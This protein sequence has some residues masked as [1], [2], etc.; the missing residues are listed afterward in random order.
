[1]TALAV[2]VLATLGGVDALSLVSLQGFSFKAPVE[3]AK[4]APDENSLE[5]TAPDEVAKFAVSAYPTEKFM[6]PAGCIKK[7]LEAVGKEGFETMTL[8]TQPA[9]K[10]VTTDFVG[11]GEAAKVDANRVTTTTV[12]GCNGRVKWLMTYSAKTSEGPRYGPIFKRIL[13]SISYGK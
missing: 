4:Q 10:K 9:A 6:L 11:E 2:S 7:M 8:A 13:D 1:M 12:M 3:W 5:W